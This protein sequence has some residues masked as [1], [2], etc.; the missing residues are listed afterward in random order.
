[1]SRPGAE[2]VDVTDP[3]ALKARRPGR[4]MAELE[5]FV[6]ADET[7]VFFTSD[8]GS[9]FPTRNAECRRSCHDACIRIPMLAH[10]PDLRPAGEPG[11]ACSEL[12]AL[13][14][15]PAHRLPGTCMDRRP[16]QL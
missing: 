13:L 7:L 8:H 14:L 5:E 9:H 15:Q 2:N 6:V 10:G 3:N 16:R 4:L 11:P 12:P 1:M